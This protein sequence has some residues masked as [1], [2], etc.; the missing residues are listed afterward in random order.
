MQIKRTDVQH[1]IQT[2]RSKRIGINNE[3]GRHDYDT[4]IAVME[5][6]MKQ[7]VSIKTRRTGLYRRTNNHG[8]DDC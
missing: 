8:C 1:A 6:Y 3:W 4:A 7:T 2:M 5:Q